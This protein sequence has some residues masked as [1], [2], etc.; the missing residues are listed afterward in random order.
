MITNKE[1]KLIVSLYKDAVKLVPV[2]NGET[3]QHWYSRIYLLGLV[4]AD[5]LELMK[6]AVLV[7]VSAAYTII[8]II[9]NH[10]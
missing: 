1:W 5:E 10:L 6:K 4:T 9:C 2:D 7:P 3:L 8:E